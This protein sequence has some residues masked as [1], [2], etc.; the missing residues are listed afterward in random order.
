MHYLKTKPVK[1]C[2]RRGGRRIG[3]QGLQCLDAKVDEMLAKITRQ[4]NYGINKTIT[5]EMIE[6]TI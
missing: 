6:I 4:Y 5:A 1:E 3:K 2:L